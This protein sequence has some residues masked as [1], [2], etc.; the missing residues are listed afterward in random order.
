[1]DWA[2]ESMRLLRRSVNTEAHAIE[3]VQ[4]RQRKRA[5][6]MRPSTIRAASFRMSPQTGLLTSTVA[7]APGSSPAL[8]GLRKWSR[9]ASLNI[10]E[11]IPRQRHDCNATQIK[12]AQRRDAE[13][14]EKKQLAR[15]LVLQE[16]YFFAGKYFFS[17]E[18]TTT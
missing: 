7:V 9:T 14:A 3:V 4:P 15:M 2:S 18:A 12:T 6:A 10:P 5:S 11:S 17:M 8:R 1:M 16:I 13:F